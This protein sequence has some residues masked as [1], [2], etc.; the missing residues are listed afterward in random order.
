MQHGAGSGLDGLFFSG[1]DGSG[2]DASLWRSFR[3]A[4]WRKQLTAWSG[5]S[6]SWITARAA[7]ASGRRSCI[8]R[9]GRSSSVEFT[10]AIA[11]AARSI[12]NWWQQLAPSIT[13]IFARRRRTEGLH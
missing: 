5:D 8:H 4:S 11:R 9:A 12:L 3:A 2:S 7:R 13:S 6:R 10:R 1:T